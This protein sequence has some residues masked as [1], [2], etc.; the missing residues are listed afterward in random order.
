MVPARSP[1]CRPREGPRH[2]RAAGLKG[3]GKKARQAGVE[4]VSGELL[5]QR[6]EL[7]P[8]PVPAV[9]GAGVGAVLPPGQPGLWRAAGGRGEMRRGAPGA[10]GG[11][12]LGRSFSP[13]LE[14]KQSLCACFRE[15]VGQQASAKQQ[16]HVHGRAS[17]RAEAM[18]ALGTSS[19]GRMNSPLR[20]GMPCGEH[21]PS[22]PQRSR[23]GAST[24]RS[25]HNRASSRLS[26]LA[27][28][29]DR[30]HPLRSFI[31]IVSLRA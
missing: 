14:L 7:R 23:A 30:W 12:V 28:I 1:S 22:A 25:T 27:W 13:P 8:D 24:R 31:R 18:S 21:A 16:Q 17:V 5:K 20:W 2:A 15:P 11:Q 10:R 29:F 6:H 3:K 9:G 26:S 4:G 19:K